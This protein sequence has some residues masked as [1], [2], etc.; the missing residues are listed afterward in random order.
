MNLEQVFPSSRDLDIPLAVASEFR[1]T[2]V[3]QGL[4]PGSRVAVGA[5]SRGISNI[6]KVVAA[7]IAN[8]RAAGAEPFLVPAMGSHGGATPEGQLEVLA[9]Y[10]ITSAQMGVPIHAAM[11]AEQIGATT[12]GTPVFFSSEAYRADAIVVV[13]RVKP[14]TD[15]GGRLG[16]GILKMLVI[17]FGKRRGATAFH[18]AAMRLGHEHAIRT[19]A[20]VILPKAPFLCGVAIL[21]DHAHATAKIE[22]LRAS[23]VESREEVLVEE[24][25]AFMPRLPFGEI[26]LLIVDQIGK[27]I[28]GSGMDPNV[29]GRAVQGGVFSVP[30][31]IAM[32]MIRRIFVRGVTES[33]HGNAVGIGLADFTRSDVLGGIN[34]DSSYIN[35]L[36][37]LSPATV[38][39]PIHFATDRE[40]IR[41]ALQSAAV[42]EGIGPRVL[43]IVDTLNLRHLQASEA[44][45]DEVRARPDLRA[46]SQPARM[47]FDNAGNLL[48][49]N[50]SI[51]VPTS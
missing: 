9:S 28:S 43:R 11:D 44:Y 34:W 2:G 22:V 13:N 46:V 29:T 25:R 48:P 47:A 40:V 6:A 36:T 19:A 7:V 33:S 49:M 3:L 14:H 17:G 42:P 37:A 18:A 39:I 26:D 4:R 1:R 31:G 10:G 21:E 23:E 35:A 51:A 24:A 50:F 20:R 27:N 12:D 38:K 32:P 30:G 5:G 45:G 41:V 16:S 15:F 8:L